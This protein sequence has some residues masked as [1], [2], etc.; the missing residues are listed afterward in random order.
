MR[1]IRS[2]AFYL[3]LTCINLFISL[4]GVAAGE[5][6]Q[7][8]ISF[9][10]PEQP[11]ESSLIEFALQAN[12]TIIADNDL[13]KGN[14]SRAVSGPLTIDEAL[15]S[16]I[17]KSPL[18]YE[19]YPSSASYIIQAKKTATFSAD[20][21]PIEPLIEIVDGTQ[22]IEE[23]LV[24]GI[25]FPFR[26]STVVNT[27]LHGGESY[28]DSSRFLNV[29]PQEL[30]QDQKATE[31]G[32]L[33][34]YASGVTPGDGVSDTNDDVFVRGFRRHAIYVDGFRLSDSTGVKIFPANTERVEILK[35][36]STL[37][38]G[39]AEPGGII[40][41][42]RKR[43][44]ADTFLH[45]E[46]GTGSLGKQYINLDVNT[47]IPTI[48]EIDFRLILVDDSQKTSGEINDIQ[49]QLIAPS[50]NWKIS[51]DTN[52]DVNYQYQY[53]QHIW[54]RGFQVL[55]PYQNIFPGVNLDQVSKSARPDF[56]TN[57]NL[58]NIEVSHNFSSDWKIRA[59]YFWQQEDRIGIRT[60]TETLLK[61]DLLFKKSE[62]GNLFI[63]LVLG[64]N[65]TVPI[66]FTPAAPEALFSIGKIRN[67]Y[68]EKAEETANNATVNLDGSFTT[69]NYT[70]RVALG[71]GWHRQ[72]IYKTYTV[73]E[74]DL[75]A[76]QFWGVS[77]FNNLVPYITD[78]ITSSSRSLGILADDEQR[79]L[80]DDYGY[81]LQDNIDLNERWILSGGTR[82]TETRGQYVDITRWL[83]SNLQTYRKFSSQL[84]LVYKPA[85][86]ISYFVNYSE[87]L[88]ANYHIDDLGSRIAQPELSDQFEIGF[89]SLLFEGRFLSSVAFF[90]IHK[91]NITN[92]KVIDGV[93]TSL[94]GHQQNMRG[95]DF[96]FTWQASSKLNLMGAVSVLKP[97]NISG[98]N[99][100]KQPALVANKTAS[101]FAHYVVNDAVEVSGGYKYVSQRFGYSGSLPTI[102]A[103]L[104]VDNQK[105]YP[106]PSYSTLELDWVYKFNSF[107]FKP[108]FQLS[109]K[110][111]LDK[112]YYT[113]I[114]GPV[115]TNV[116]EGRSMVGSLKLE[117]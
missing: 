65:E 63:L 44:R 13:I 52:I 10:L 20:N 29:L 98:K 2:F 59:N 31:L 3:L 34:K 26:Y 112:D 18:S 116:S 91:K 17:S 7:K 111:A 22:K 57:F 12:I 109:I 8:I 62:L 47:Q 70:H 14:R 55:G 5:A 16:L 41:V 21:S 85:D 107:S 6:S 43:P 32:D 33:L 67:L 83:V 56:N 68:D 42:I 110:N 76:S 39:Q 80:Y 37:L 45:A 89:K 95:I 23:I 15:S 105:T 1:P 88:R 69:G 60:D 50:I 25:R 35:G 82:Y 49:K 75:F 74:R 104:T 86:N 46:L 96:D 90:D 87:A 101:L 114:V 64:G 102:G 30:I 79:L 27:Q 117:F 77:E 97:D 9:D 48:S 51:D 108:Q 40:N 93:R 99:K 54:G 66:V 81:Y 28:F 53:A 113:A 72:D 115:R 36:P 100:G 61:S 92:L 94:V 19:Y 71:G 11:L 4:S 38:F 58:Y 103:D 73:E 78:T 24:T 106:L 84:G